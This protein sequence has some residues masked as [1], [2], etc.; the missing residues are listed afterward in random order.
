MQGLNLDIS[1]IIL[2]SR[3]DL[4][5]YVAPNTAGKAYCGSP[6]FCTVCASAGVCLLD[7]EE[8]PS[9]LSNCY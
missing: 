7:L 5:A 1:V 9:F 4:D 6:I 3:N 8:K 2:G